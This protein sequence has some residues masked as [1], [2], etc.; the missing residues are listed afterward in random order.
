M[1]RRQKK[2]GPHGGKREGAGR[3]TYFTGKKGS[4][5]FSVLFTRVGLKI[6]ERRRAAVKASRSD[7]LQTLVLMKALSSRHARGVIQM[8]PGKLP[9]PFVLLFNERGMR[10]LDAMTKEFGKSRSNVLESLL[11]AYADEITSDTIAEMA[12]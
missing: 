1:V 8:W 4:R 11:Q 6:L 7:F 10:T 3:P 12:A 9:R 2:K 5:Q